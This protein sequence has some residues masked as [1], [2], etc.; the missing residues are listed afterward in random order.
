MKDK[1]NRHGAVGKSSSNN[2]FINPMGLPLLCRICGVV[3]LVLPGLTAGW[4]A[5]RRN[6]VNF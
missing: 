5:G 6:P 1:R 4:L 2:S 3:H